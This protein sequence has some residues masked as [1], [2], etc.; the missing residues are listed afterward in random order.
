MH[1]FYAFRKCVP[2]KE[3]KMGYNPALRFLFTKHRMIKA[4]RT[5]QRTKPLRILKFNVI[6]TNCHPELYIYL[7]V[8]NVKT[9]FAFLLLI[10]LKLIRLEALSHL[11]QQHSIQ[12]PSLI[13]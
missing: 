12:V 2:F 10:P 8:E 3:Q 1:H 9:F 7:A 11:P 4:S 5:H 6:M 13:T